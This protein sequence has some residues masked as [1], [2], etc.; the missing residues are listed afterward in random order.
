MLPVGTEKMPLGLGLALMVISIICIIINYNNPSRLQKL[1][2]FGIEWK[3]IAKVLSKP[4]VSKW[5]SIVSIGGTGGI[6]SYQY[7]K[8]VGKIE[9]FSQTELVEI[10]KSK[11]IENL[12]TLNKTITDQSVE[13]V[14]LYHSKESVKD[15][16]FIKLYETSVAKAQQGLENASELTKDLTDKWK[17]ASNESMFPSPLE[18]WDW[19]SWSLE[20]WQWMAISL[21]I[22]VLNI[23]YVIMSN[24]L[25]P[26]IDKYIEEKEGEIKNKWILKVIKRRKELGLWT[27]IMNKILFIV[28]IFNII[29][30]FSSIILIKLYFLYFKT[31]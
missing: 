28:S 23:M 7:G 9:K 27:K 15:P 3:A 25:S 13:I 31:W 4:A 2:V 16:A 11:N 6:A 14:K 1:N 19:S 8:E 21:T 5:A 12:L 17:G 26:L 20:W 29:F 24:Q 22:S 18:V 30:V 10:V